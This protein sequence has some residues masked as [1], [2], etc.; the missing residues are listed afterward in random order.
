MYECKR[1]PTGSNTCFIL[2]PVA[3]SHQ[4]DA[5]WEAHKQVNKLGQYPIPALV[6][7]QMV[8][9]GILHLILDAAYCHHD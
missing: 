8:S 2:E 5:S 4:P 9:R 3:K 6:P 1:S 7:Y